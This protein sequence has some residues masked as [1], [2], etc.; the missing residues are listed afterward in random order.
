M[1]KILVSPSILNVDFTN[2]EKECLSLQQSGADW[3]HCDI[4]D[5]NFVHNISFGASVVK[6][7]KKVSNIPLDVH[8]MISHPMEYAKDFV[9]SGANIVTFHIESKDDTRETASLIKKL[10]A[11]VG[12]AVKPETPV[13]KLLPFADLL[14]LVLV[15][16]VEPGFGG[17]SFKAECL[18]K[19]QTAKILFPEKFIQV[20]GG[21][22]S[23]TA[24]IAI[25]AGANVLVAGTYIISA[26]NRR[27]AISLLKNL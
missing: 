2:L 22:N 11:K 14:D 24:K 19:I 16:T 5:G 3:L 10:G 6:N 13:E 25:N 15:M 26:E 1:N 9:N 12:I 7:I 18:E 20:D 17:Q 23:E 27:N 4:M 21:I 8:L